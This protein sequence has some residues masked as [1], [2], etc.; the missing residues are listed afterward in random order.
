M[1]GAGVN[2]AWGYFD[3]IKFKKV[4]AKSLLVEVNAYHPFQAFRV[5]KLD[6]HSVKRADYS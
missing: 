2:A 6:G 5:A 1:V 4:N 3:F